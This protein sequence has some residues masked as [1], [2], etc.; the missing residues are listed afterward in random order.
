M[1]IL[2]YSDGTLTV[3]NNSDYYCELHPKPSFIT[4]D[5]FTYEPTLSLMDGAPISDELLE[6]ANDYIDNFVF[7]IEVVVEEPTPTHRV[8]EFGNYLGLCLEGIEVPSSPPEALSNP[9]WH[10]DK[11]IE[12]AIIDKDSKLF[13]GFGDNR[14]IKNSIYAPKVGMVDGFD[15]K[16]QKYDVVNKVWVID[17]EDAR[18]CRLHLIKTEYNKTI[19]V[20]YKTD[21]FVDYEPTTFQIQVTEASNWK[22]DNNTPTPFI[23]KLVE[24]RDFEGETKSSLIDKILYKNTLFLDIAGELGKYHKLLK[25]VE[26]SVTTD[27]LKKINW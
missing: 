23:D 3:I 13:L 15:T 4:G 11:Y 12:G 16:I 14:V 26:L 22:D 25:A 21:E 10:I 8:D 2:K 5:V 27:D 9:Y 24:T 1:R 7:P 17:L 18:K 19:G 20:K 6:L